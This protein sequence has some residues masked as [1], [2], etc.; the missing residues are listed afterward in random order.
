MVPVVLNKHFHI[1]KSF[2]MGQQLKIMF[3]GAD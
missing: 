3:S 2:N 1:L